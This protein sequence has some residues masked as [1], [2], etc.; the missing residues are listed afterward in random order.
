MV[1]AGT[2]NLRGAIEGG[3]VTLSVGQTLFVQN[4]GSLL[5]F[6]GITVRDGL[7]ITPTGGQPIQAFAFGR[8]INADGSTVINNDFF[9]QVAFNG[10]GSG[11]TDD[12]Q[13]N[14][15]FINSGVCRL[16]SADERIPGGPDIIEEPVQQSG[17]L[18]GAGGDDSDLVDTS[19][20]DDPLIEEPVTSGGDSAI[21]VRDCDRDDDG[22]CDGED[23]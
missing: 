20:S 3:N 23:E 10:L 13:F 16:Q 5:D 11:Y 9:R 8:R 2:P 12:A 21:W 17:F 22:D 19:F 15:C 7:T 4:M 14:L 1:N 6:A 18:F